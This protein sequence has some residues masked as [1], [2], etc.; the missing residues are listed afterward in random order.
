M[1]KNKKT[2]VIVNNKEYF[3]EDLND[4][5]RSMLNHI[6]DLD[7]KLKSARF[8]VDQLNVGREAFISMLSKSLENVDE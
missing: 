3:A 1:V 4:Q 8:N 2:P 7:R 6:Q 5:Q